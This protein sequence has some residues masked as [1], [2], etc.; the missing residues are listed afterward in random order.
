MFYINL[1]PVNELPK[2]TN[3]PRGILKIRTN[4]IL[5]LRPL[6][7]LNPRPRSILNPRPRSILNPRPRS[8]LKP[9]PTMHSTVNKYQNVSENKSP[10]VI[11]IISSTYHELAIIG[12]STH[13]DQWSM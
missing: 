1:S 6:I 4:R 5:K 9:R 7:I 12:A 3:T 2:I 8:I 13:T 10:V 11:S